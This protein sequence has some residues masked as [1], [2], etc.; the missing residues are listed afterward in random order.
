MR[1]RGESRDK[2]SELRELEM[3]DNS[4]QLLDLKTTCQR[5][6]ESYEALIQ[7]A[8]AGLDSSRQASLDARLSQ[9]RGQ[10]SENTVDYCRP[11]HTSTVPAPHACTV[12]ESPTYVGKVSD[13]HFI[14][15]VR[16]CIQGRDLLDREGLA[17]QTYGQTRISES[18]A[19]LS[20]PLLIPPREEATYF[21]E[22]YLSTIHI[23][24]PFLC[25]STIL[26]EFE[27]LWT[28]DRLKPENRPWLALFSMFHQKLL[29]RAM[30]HEIA[31]RA[32]FG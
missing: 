16:Q 18:L 12:M 3:K 10:G 2:S 32:D 17:S 22:I 15:M 13:V 29:Y 26:E 23:A 9:I 5:T 1:K 31:Q 6:V 27:R 20:H 25:K 21:L 4:Q 11:S 8:R 28:E 30:K 14:H 19:A 24:Y 7:E